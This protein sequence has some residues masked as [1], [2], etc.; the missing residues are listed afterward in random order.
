MNLL[1]LGFLSSYPECPK[2]RA[3]D[4]DKENDGADA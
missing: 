3:K 2:H 1:A 4:S